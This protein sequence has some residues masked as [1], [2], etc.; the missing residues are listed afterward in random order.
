MSGKFEWPSGFNNEINRLARDHKSNST[1]DLADRIA[2]YIESESE[3]LMPIVVEETKH[4]YGVRLLKVMAA[5][6]R[7][8]FRPQA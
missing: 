4:D 2:T 1:E 7:E 3:C 6:I 5:E 8:K